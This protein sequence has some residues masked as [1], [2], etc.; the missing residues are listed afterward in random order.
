LGRREYHW[1]IITH[2]E[3]GKP[4]LLYGDIDESRARSKG[5]ELL[6]GAD[7]EL[8]RF[9]TRDIGAASAMY[10]GKRLEQTHSLKTATE[11][12]GHEKSLKRSQQ[13]GQQKRLSRQSS[14]SNNRNN[15]KQQSSSF[16]GFGGGGF[17][18]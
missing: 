7:F 12:L 6:A 18:S 14:G 9:P 11:R 5:L 3:T 4:F 17:F 1:W 13:R 8:K 2:D 15:K 10:R 16:G